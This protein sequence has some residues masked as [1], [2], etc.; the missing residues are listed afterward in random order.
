M[1]GVAALEAA[2]GTVGT[3]VAGEVTDLT[4]RNAAYAGGEQGLE[5]VEQGL[6]DGP[7]T[8]GD[9]ALCSGM[10]GR[11]LDGRGQ[12][13]GATHSRQEKDMV[14]VGDHE[15][16]RRRGL[17]AGGGAGDEDELEG[18]ADAV[19]LLDW[20]GWDVLGPV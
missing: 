11:V 12:I 1:S 9:V 8:S 19:A 3:M 17:V 13:G 18:M 6:G 7:G 5:G 2:G 15:P 14:G 10:P 4:P 20:R 16:G